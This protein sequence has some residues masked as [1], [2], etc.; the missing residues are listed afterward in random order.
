M[1][2]Y[3]TPTPTQAALAYDDIHEARL[4]LDHEREFGRLLGRLEAVVLMALSAGAG[5]CV[6]LV[7]A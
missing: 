6:W 7:M 3:A 1:T 5:V 2:T 4:L